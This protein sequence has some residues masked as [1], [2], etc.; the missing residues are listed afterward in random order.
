MAQ[1]TEHSDGNLR[2]LLVINGTDVGGSE[3]ALCQIA[4]GLRDAGHNVQVMSLKALGRLAANLTEQKI[5]VSSLGMP[6]R[7]TWGNLLTGSWKLHRW[8]SHCD[9]DVVHS[10]LPRANILSRVAN[11]CGARRIHISSER[12]TDY[13]RSKS[14]QRLNRWTSRWTDTVLV[15]SAEVSRV[16]V[17]RREVPQDKIRILGNGIDLAAIDAEPATNLVEELGLDPGGFVVCSVGRL[18]RDKGHVFLLEALSRAVDRGVEAT[19]ILVGD[20]PEEANLRERT[21]KLGLGDRVRFLGFRRDVVGL[22]KASDVFVLPSLEEGVPVALLEAMACSLPVIASRVGGIPGLV[23]ERSTAILVPPCESWGDGAATSETL[24][25]GI[26]AL[27]DAMM[28]IYRETER[29]LTFGRRGRQRIEE[30]FTM[31][32]ITKQLLSAYAHAGATP[33]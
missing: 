29:R 27:T 33:R 5:E 21:R 28:V 13:Q 6:E 32:A 8:M 24:D 20:G 31:E 2:V 26:E 30:E 12:S 19:L 25:R 14:V 18:I 9:F 1:T 11:R 7:V 23:V 22:M 15:V 3:T 17:E 4:C 16:L 10:F